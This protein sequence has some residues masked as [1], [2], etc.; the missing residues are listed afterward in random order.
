MRKEE[1]YKNKFY[2]YYHIDPR[3][4]QVFY[5]GKGSGGRAWVVYSRSKEHTSKVNEIKSLSLLPIIKI[6][7]VFDNEK[8]ALDREKIVISF[9]IRAGHP[10]LN[11]NRGGGGHP[12]GPGHHAFGKKLS[13]DRKKKISNALKGKPR[14]DLSEKTR[15]RMKGNTV[16]RG[17][18]MSG[19]AKEMISNSLK[20]NSNRSLKII[21]ENNGKI[22]NSVKEAWTELGL[23]ERS[24]FRVLKGQYNNTKGYRFR[25]L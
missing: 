16:R 24:V 6:A 17:K 12:G 23:D 21:C 7:H 1:K 4:S 9:L 13:D 11:K 20:G 18:S 8:D 25:Y 3:T 19:E 5:A 2:I 15:E 14:P 22:Y 10:L